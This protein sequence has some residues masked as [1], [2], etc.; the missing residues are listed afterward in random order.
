[1]RNR[2]IHFI[3]VTF[4]FQ[5]FKHQRVSRQIFKFIFLKNIYKLHKM[6]FTVL[7]CALKLFNAPLSYTHLNTHTHSHIAKLLLAT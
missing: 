4:R 3:L 2:E 6:E 7:F 5:V 1:M